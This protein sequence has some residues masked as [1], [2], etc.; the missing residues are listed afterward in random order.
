MTAVIKFF[1]YVYVASS[2]NTYFSSERSVLERSGLR[3]PPFV[4]DDEDDED[5]EEE[6][7]EE[8]QHAMST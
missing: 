2:S 1:T 8:L 5:K 3:T 7:E 6:E 4:L